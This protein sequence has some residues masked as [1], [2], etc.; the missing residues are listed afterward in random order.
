LRTILKDGAAGGAALRATVVLLSAAGCSSER[1]AQLTEV[2]PR[3][4]RDCRRRW[5]DSGIAGL[6]DDP[7]SGRPK[8]ADAAYIRL[9]IR[10]VT[11]D[12]R[13]L[14]FAFSRWSTARLATYMA[15]Q[16]GA[17]LNPHYVAELLHQ[18]RLTW[19]K[20]KLTIRNLAD[21]GEKKASRKALESSSNGLAGG[22]G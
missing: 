12:P 21:E 13:K 14:G 18:H 22:W 9:L 10:T 7:R 19:G 11:K 2:S 15:R 20:S 17:R 5:R 3:N 1:I 4:V 6:K 8:L 16:T